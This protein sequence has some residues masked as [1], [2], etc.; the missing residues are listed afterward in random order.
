MIRDTFND[1]AIKNNK[2][3]HS[4]LKNLW[5]AIEEASKNDRPIEMLE[6]SNDNIKEIN[7]RLELTGARFQQINKTGVSLPF[8]I[9]FNTLQNKKMRKKS[10]VLCTP[11]VEFH[12][13][14]VFVFI[15]FVC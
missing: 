14:F 6:I 12:F 13:F 11:L 9:G 15:F 3:V 1:Y 10:N 5:V 4:F 7:R 2:D 8:S